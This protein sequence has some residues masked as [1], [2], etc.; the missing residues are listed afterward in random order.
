MARIQN[1]RILVWCNE[2]EH[3]KNAIFDAVFFSLKLET[4]LCFFANFRSK[5]EEILFHERVNQY[6][7]VVKTDVPELSVS[8]LLLKGKLQNL[9]NVLSDQYG[10]ILLFCGNNFRGELVNAFYKSGF[11]FFFSKKGEN[12]RPKFLNVLIPID[13][14]SSTKESVLWGSYAGRFFNSDITLLKANET[15]TDQRNKVEKITAFVRRLYG[16]FL[17]SFRF[18]NG[19]SNSWGIHKE[20]MKLANNFDLVI[21]TGSYNVSIV[22]KVIGTFEKQLINLGGETSILLIN[23]QVELCVLCN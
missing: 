13:S 3:L 4:E 5:P 16:Q 19:Q 15:D 11:P 7:N 6:A 21:F 17:F 12:V 9:M 8:T 1:Q 23:P 18:E 14:R 2:D 20:A 22:D 10:A